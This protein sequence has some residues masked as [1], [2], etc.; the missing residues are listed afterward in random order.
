MPVDGNEDDVW[1]GGLRGLLGRGHSGHCPAQGARG[2]PAW[3]HARMCTCAPSTPGGQ[4]HSKT[5]LGRSAGFWDQ[6]W[7]GPAW[8]R[9]SG[10]GRGPPSPRRRQ[11]RR[12]AT[13][14]STSGRLSWPPAPSYLCACRRPGG[15]SGG[16]EGRAREGQSQGPLHLLPARGHRSLA[17][18]HA[19]G[20]R[21]HLQGTCDGRFHPM[22]MNV[23]SCPGST[24]CPGPAGVPGRNSSPW[25]PPQPI[26]DL[27]PLL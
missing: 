21:L 20:R 7:A 19:L 17:C 26:R 23:L 12:W 16:G 18:P 14:R 3:T 13:G 9:R 24:W 5:C 11:T 15:C 22:P 10:W 6:G 8:A 25:A 1:V 2:P 4:P 27:F